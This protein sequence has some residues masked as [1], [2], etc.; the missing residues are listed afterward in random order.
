MELKNIR[1]I[2]VLYFDP[3]LWIDPNDITRY[4]GIFGY[5]DSESCVLGEDNSFSEFTGIYTHNL[6]EP[7]LILNGKKESGPKR[8]RET[9]ILV[10]IG[11]PVC[12]AGGSIPHSFLKSLS[13]ED[14]PED[15]IEQYTNNLSEFAEKRFMRERRRVEKEAIESAIRAYQRREDKI[16]EDKLTQLL[17]AAQGR[18]ERVK[19]ERANGFIVAHRN[20]DV[21]ARLEDVLGEKKFEESV[22]YTD[23]IDY[24]PRAD[25]PSH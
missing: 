25:R 18:V 19:L 12:E 4:D 8:K 3:G 23:V 21:L 1:N 5:V 16:S 24:V 10:T 20:R 15:I 9:N 11:K 17:E 2:Y 22:F 14:N 13:R 6:G 7:I